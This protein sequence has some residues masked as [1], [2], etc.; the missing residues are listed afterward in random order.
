MNNTIAS[1]DQEP[2]QADQEQ[3]PEVNEPPQQHENLA[4]NL[5]Q[6]LGGQQ[7]AHG[8]HHAGGQ[9]NAPGGGAP[10]LL[11]GNLQRPLCGNCQRIGHR[12]QDCR[13]VSFCSRCLVEGHQNRSHYQN[14]NWPQQRPDGNQWNNIQFQ[15]GGTNQDDQQVPMNHINGPNYDP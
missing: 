5:Q 6:H 8:S 1:V 3:F 2:M 12:W 14:Q 10:P 15:F 9:Q 4:V 13:W 11:N 7:N